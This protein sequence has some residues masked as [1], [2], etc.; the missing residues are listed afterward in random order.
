MKY[1][2]CRRAGN[3]VMVAGLVVMVVSIGF[4]IANQLP[5]FHPASILTQAAV[6]GIFV[7]ALLWLAGARISG[8]EK[9]EDRLFWHRHYDKRCRRTGHGPQH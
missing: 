5:G 1:H 4:S 9:V 6:L 8:R 2:H 3:S 7:G